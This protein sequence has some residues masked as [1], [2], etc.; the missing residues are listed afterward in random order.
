M[1]S[2]A[3]ALAVVWNSLQCKIDLE[4]NNYIAT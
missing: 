2:L 3:D 4:T 1:A